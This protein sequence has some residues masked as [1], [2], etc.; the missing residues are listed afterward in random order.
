MHCQFLFPSLIGS[1]GLVVGAEFRRPANEYVSKQQRT[2]SPSPKAGSHYQQR[3]ESTRTDAFQGQSN[4]NRYSSGT[5]GSTFASDNIEK[6]IE[7]EGEQEPDATS[8]PEQNV[9]PSGQLQARGN[10]LLWSIPFLG[11]IISYETYG[12]VSR[13]FLKGVQ[14]ASSNTWIPKSRED[15][16]LQTN[17]VV[18]SRKIM[19]SALHWLIY[20]F[21]PCSWLDF[22]D[23]SRE[24]TW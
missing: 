10:V 21:S 7:Q 18:R 15:I 17:V 8:P 16:D 4:Y 23:P 1:A 6:E 3:A 24:W 11:C 9:V 19:R 20:R 5:Y 12:Q 13:L 14:W 22:A 2:L